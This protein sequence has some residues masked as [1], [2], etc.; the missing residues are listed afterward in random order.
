MRMSDEPGYLR[1]A[2]AL[3]E[4]IR[5]DGCYREIASHADDGAIDFASNDYL[6]LSTE[7]QVVQAFKQA[8]RTSSGGSR[9]LSGRH[10]EHSLLEEELAQWLG[11][12]RVLLFSSGYHAALGALP[13]LSLSVDSIASDEFNHASLIDGMRLAR[14]PR[15]VYPH[16]EF[17]AK[18]LRG[19][20]TL[21]V[22]ESIFSMGGD[23]VDPRSLLDELGNDDALFVDEAHAI[24]VT[25]PSGSGLARELADSRVVVM[26]TLSK[27]LGA[28]GGFVAGPSQ[29]IELLVNR[30]RS[31]V[32]DTALPP[33][34]ALA[35]RV[36]IVLARRADDRRAR[37]AAN[38]AR[39]RAGLRELGFDAPDSVSPIV[40]VILG[41]QER[42]VAFSAALRRARINAPAIR[43]PTVPPGSSRLRFSMRSNHTPE[44]IDL[45]VKEL[46]RCIATL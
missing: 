33:A 30:A 11:R 16:A 39:L 8:T 22:S 14:V 1:R 41:S 38:A 42:A 19:T 13:V 5:A 17:P 28:H 27:A 23:V 4:G 9:L 35:G 44:Q 32:F 37:L 3:L 31:F 43:P 6:G 46:R 34:I 40:P 10:R 15:I 36:A 29:V 25:G 26:G 12:E 45:V 24:G 2:D 18:A 7:P 20:S 21:A